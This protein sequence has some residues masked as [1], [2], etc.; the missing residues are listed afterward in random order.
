MN[1]LCM[2]L[3]ALIFALLIIGILIGLSIET[4]Y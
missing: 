3:L 1:K 2:I 4:F